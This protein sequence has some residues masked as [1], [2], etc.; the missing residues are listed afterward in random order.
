MACEMAGVG[1]YPWSAWMMV[2]TPLAANT[3]RA[4]PKAASE[5]ACVSNPTKRGPVTPA[6]ARCSTSA[7]LTASTWASLNAPS[8]ERPRWPEVP[9]L[10][11]WPGSSGSGSSV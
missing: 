4:L 6:A 3:S 9:K 7:W 5:S 10:T 1:V 11:R 2:S 8:R